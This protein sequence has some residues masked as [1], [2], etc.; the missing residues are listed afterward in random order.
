MAKPRKS[1]SSDSWKHFPGTRI[2]NSINNSNSKSSVITGLMKEGKR[3][4][5]IQDWNLYTNAPYLEERPSKSN[6]RF[7]DQQDRLVL[8]HQNA[9]HP[10]MT[11][12]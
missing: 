4:K 7:G 6:L 9:G 2:W 11:L 10:V 5:H 1:S 8:M 3:K 12:S